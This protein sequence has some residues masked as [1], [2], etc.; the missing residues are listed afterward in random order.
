MKHHRGSA[1]NN[2]AGSKGGKG[3]KGKGKQGN[4]R[5]G[6]GASSGAATSGGTTVDVKDVPL[7]FADLVHPDHQ[8][9]VPRYV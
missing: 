7:T 6:V 2:S 3:Q 9:W 1:V 5:G 8:G 4:P